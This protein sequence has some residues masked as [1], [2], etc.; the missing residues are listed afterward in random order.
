MFGRRDSIY[1][2]L[3]QLT[4]AGTGITSSVT[5]SKLP[6]GV[7]A[8]SRQNTMRDIWSPHLSQQ[9]LHRK[10]TAA[11]SSSGLSKPSLPPHPHS[12]HREDFSLKSKHSRSSLSQ[13]VSTHLSNSSDSPLLPLLKMLVMC[14]C[15][16]QLQLTPDRTVTSCPPYFVHISISVT[17][18]KPPYSL[19]LYCLSP[20][21]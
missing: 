3:R 18:P 10:L 13:P 5:S 11:H 4:D 1:P 8:C 20:S 15:S 16:R 17:Q 21:S 12:C 14:S 19:P 9:T 7:A 6:G 2:T